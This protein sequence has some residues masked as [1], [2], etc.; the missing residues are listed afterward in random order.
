MKLEG[1]AAIVTGGARGIGLHTCHL[2]GAHRGRL[3]VV[4]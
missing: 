2:D 1:K 3:P 4:D